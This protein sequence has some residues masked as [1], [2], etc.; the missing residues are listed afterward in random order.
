MVDFSGFYKLT[1]DERLAKLKAGGLVNDDDI[2]LLK[3]SGALKLDLADRMV[4]NVIGVSHLPMGL[5][6]NFVIN[7]KEYVVPMMIEEPSVIA[8]ASNAAKLA[9]ES[10]GFTA[11]ADEPV[12]IGQ[13]QFVNISDVEKALQIIK[14]KKDEIFTLAKSYA[15]QIERY[16]GGVKEIHARIL[17]TIRGKMIIVEFYVDVRDAM[18]ANTINTVLEGVAPT[19]SEMIKGKTRLRI[20]SNLAVK[21]KVTVTAVWK[22]ELIGE[23]AIEG[24]LDAYAFADSDIFRCA[25][26]NKGIMN[27]IDAVALATGNDWRAVEAGAHAFA[28]MLGYKPLTQYEKNA[29]GNLVGTI[30]L[31]I[32]A[33]TV[34]GAINTSPLAKVSLKLLGIKTSKELSMVMAAVGL[35]NNFAALRALSTEGIQKGHMKLHARNIAVLAGA[36][37]GE[38]IDTV[39]A[40][41]AK[42]HNYDVNFAKELLVKMK[43]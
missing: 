39:A 42:S 25:T 37:S 14:E 20:L 40:E 19:I 13:I 10:G 1:V 2:K 7:G 18:G 27:G 26:H 21:R 3:D 41:L 32:A 8:A 6:T 4:E 29:D 34:G 38:E 9:K 35:A 24:I 11:I 36:T 15:Q 5:A 17:P 12:M 16:G 33:G 22:K 43:K 23:E 30:T 28:A 31:P